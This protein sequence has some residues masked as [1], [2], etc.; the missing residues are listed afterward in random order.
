MNNR[1]TWR[2]LA[3]S[4]VALVALTGATAFAQGK[5]QAKG[6]FKN[7]NQGGAGPSAAGAP[8]L[9]VS[10]T[11]VRNFGSWLDDASVMEQGRGYVS[12]AFSYWRT[13]AYR[14]ID[15][16][17]VDAYVGL[18]PRVQFGASVPYY[19]ASEPGGPVARGLGDLYLTAKVQLRDPAVEGRHVGFAVTPLLE[20]LSFAPQPG[21]SRAS[22]ALPASIEVRQSGWRVF[23]SGG[24]FSRGSIFASAALE[25]A[26]GERAAATG[27]IS[28]SH[29]IDRDDLA[30]ALG[31]AQTRTDV[32]AGLGVAITPGM[33]A[34][35][36]VGRTISVRDAHSSTLALTTGVA[37]FFDAWQRGSTPRLQ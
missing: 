7:Q 15:V 18:T 11:G 19:H 10:G 13:P 4:A 30:V 3:A 5:G 37:F 8:E 36:S 22:W 24:Y 2:L 31:L 33:S 23:A 6:H 25:V 26:L 14:E 17:V 35:A 29:S 16:P 21:S 28:R 9:Q 32:T 20:V 1:S 12:L 27:S 34:F